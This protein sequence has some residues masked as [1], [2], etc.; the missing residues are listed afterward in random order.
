MPQITRK[1]LDMAIRLRRYVDQ[2]DTTVQELCS[3]ARRHAQTYST[4]QETW[5]NVELNE[6]Q[7]DKLERREAALERR[8]TEILRQLYPWPNIEYRGDPRG[9]TVRITLPDGSTYG[10]DV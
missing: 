10:L 3:L 7:T 4:I 1:G 2:T 9:H 6:R 5:C 8:M